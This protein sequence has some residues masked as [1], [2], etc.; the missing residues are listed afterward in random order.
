MGAAR[1]FALK[2]SDQDYID[3]M[4]VVRPQTCSRGCCGVCCE[5]PIM[6]VE[7]PPGN[8][9]A[10]ITEKYVTTVFL[11]GHLKS[12]LIFNSMSKSPYWSTCSSKFALCLY[13]K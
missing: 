10:Y 1:S 4:K 3:I 13:C 5:L 7:N 6:Y 8:R 9:I 12:L 2:F 11:L